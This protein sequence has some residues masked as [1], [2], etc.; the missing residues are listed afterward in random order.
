MNIMMKNNERDVLLY[1]K[2]IGIWD[3][4]TK[5]V[6]QSDDFQKRYS[7]YIR[8][9]EDLRV[10]MNSGQNINKSKLFKR[11]KRNLKCRGAKSV[12]DS[13][14]RDAEE[15]DEFCNFTPACASNDLLFSVRQQILVPGVGSL[16]LPSAHI[17]SS[18]K[19]LKNS[20][21]H[22]YDILLFV[23]LLTYVLIM[24]QRRYHRFTT[25]DPPNEMETR[26]SVI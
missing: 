15:I 18:P 3:H 7:E 13:I 8:M 4:D 6:L 10:Y 19:P 20:S 14:D 21:A 24:T 16:P 9:L 22:Y 1:N 12:C 26:G 2:S 23:F 25:K 11:K 5:S 17:L